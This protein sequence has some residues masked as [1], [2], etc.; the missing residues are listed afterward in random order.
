MTSR[1]ADFKSAAYAIPPLARTRQS[2]RSLAPMSTRAESDTVQIPIDR[3][4]FLGYTPAVGLRELPHSTVGPP[5]RSWA[6]YE[7]YAFNRGD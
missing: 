7:Q 2:T 1:S 5:L 3:Q 6:P 4:P